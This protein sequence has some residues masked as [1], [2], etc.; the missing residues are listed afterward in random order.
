ML[1]AMPSA[2]RVAAL[3]AFSLI[4]A[5][6]S[7]QADRYELGLRLRAFERRLAATADQERRREAFAELNEAV[8]AFFGMDMNRV[9]RAVGKAEEALEGRAR[10][11]DE[12]WAA[13][14][15]LRLPQRLCDPADEHA[16]ATLFLLPPPRGEDALAMPADVE[17]VALLD[18]RE[19]L[20]L[21]MTPPPMELSLPIAQHE[22]GDLALQWRVAAKGRVLTSREQGLS[23][24]NNLDARLAALQAHE[25]PTDAA[26]SLEG[27]TLAS[28]LRLLQG[29]KKARS[30]ETMLPGARLLQQAEELAAA[31]KAD[32]DAPWFGSRRTGQFWLRVPTA[33]G[34]VSVRLLVPAAAADGSPRP[35]VLALHGAGGSENLFFDGYGDGAIVRLCEERGFLLCA[36]RSSGMTG[37]A[38]PALVEALAARFAV[39]RSATLLLG[40]SMGAMQAMSQAGAA[41]ETF[42]AVAALGGGGNARQ[43][44]RLRAL[45]FFVA[46]GER[47]FGRAGAASLA[48][49]LQAFGAPCDFRIY[50]DVEHLAIVQ[51]ALPDV[52]SFFDS[53]LQG[54]ERR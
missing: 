12:R 24:A 15:C 27:A 8:Q 16:K 40:H 48:Q 42:C 37:V 20:R 26:L 18:G 25:P 6:L 3:A 29:M 28:H 52:F 39:D 45:P 5:A 54:R 38:L 41:P 1:G 10:D 23:L 31:E 33:R 22:D 14:L 17:F 4:A 9:A 13:Q 53:A 44:E 7:A 19:A 2:P 49:K 36:P 11:G 21:P 34:L 35:L 51:V 46:A 47:D 30:E 32:G 43:S 50:P